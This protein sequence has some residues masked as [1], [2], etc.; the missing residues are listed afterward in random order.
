MKNQVFLSGWMCLLLLAGTLF[1][2]DCSTNILSTVPFNKTLQS[3]EATMALQL[4]SSAFAQGQPIPAKYTCVGQNISPALTWTSPPQNTKSF[5]LIVDD[6]DAPSGTFVHWVLCNIPAD[7]RALQ[8][9]AT[10]AGKMQAG[11]N[12]YGTTK[13]QGPCPPSGTHR[14]FFKLYALDTVLN[15]KEGLSKEQLLEAMN[16][17]ILDQTELMGTFHK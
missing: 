1:C 9:N 4:T 15:V 7:T 2:K 12:S 17:H 16:G 8:E 10:P 14:Y 5:A 6:P 3:M 11:K 13:Y